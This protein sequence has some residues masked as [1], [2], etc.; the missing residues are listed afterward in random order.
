MIKQKIWLDTDIGED[1]D[2]AYALALILASPE[3]DL[4]GI[5]TV[6]QNVAA[7]ARLAKTI[8]QMAGQSHIP[9]AAGC[10]AVLSPRICKLIPEISECQIPVQ[11]TA[12][13]SLEDIDL[14]QTALA[15][16][17][18]QL[19]PAIP[20]HGVDFLIKNIMDGKGDIILFT[21]GPMTNI[22][23]AL[24]KEPRL[25]SKI[26]R[27]ISMAGNF[28]QDI[29]EWNIGWDPVAAAIVVNTGI[30]MTFT[31]FD[32][33]SRCKLSSSQIDLL[34]SS[35]QKLPQFLAKLTKARGNNTIF[36]HDPLAIETL[37]N[38]TVVQTE[39]GTVRVELADPR[40]GHTIFRKAQSSIRSPHDICVNVNEEQAVN[41]WLTRVLHLNLQTISISVPQDVPS[42]LNAT[43]SL[44]T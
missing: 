18:E 22:A 24:I 21:I 39:N 20:V 6:F 13:F 32:M 15:L 19:S 5:T 28:Q 36:L 25:I 12:K 37:I 17:Q 2:D 30:P 23:M 29:P 9:V 35:T 44:P 40:Y 14:P 3:L 41:F 4:L 31:G 7:K 27:I 34:F 43:L 33:T 11:E 8:L 38:P 16:P 10:G 1:I 26:Q 42:K